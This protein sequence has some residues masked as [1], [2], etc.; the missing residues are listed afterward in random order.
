M[1][2]RSRTRIIERSW[3]IDNREIMDNLCRVNGSSDY[4]CCDRCYGKAPE[5]DFQA[6]RLNAEAKAHYGSS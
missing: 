5:A 3:I 4:S 2:N 1:D 6:V